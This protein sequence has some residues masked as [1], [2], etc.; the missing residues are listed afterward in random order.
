LSFLRAFPAAK[1]YAFEPDRRAA[2]KFKELI[3][4]KRVELFEIALGASDGEAEFYVSSGLPP[5]ATP[6]L[7]VQYT[8]G[9]DMSGSLRAPKNHTTVWPW[10][11]FESRVTVPVRRLDSWAAEH[12]IGAIDFIWAD[13]QGAEGDLIAGGKAC[14]ARTRYFYTEYSDDEWY[15]GQPSLRQLAQMLSGFVIIRRFEMDVL[16]KNTAM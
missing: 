6:E 9:W 10:C 7:A 11:K 4:D 3:A 16:F 13:V 5:G 2:S 12:D 14:M 15:E 1:I 8:Q